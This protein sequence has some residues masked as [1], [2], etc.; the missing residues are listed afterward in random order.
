[1]GEGMGR[2]IGGVS[3]LGGESSLGGGIC[4][5]SIR[6]WIMACSLLEASAAEHWKWSIILPLAR[7]KVSLSCSGGSWSAISRHVITHGA[8]GDCKI[9]GGESYGLMEGCSE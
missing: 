1:M 8:S 9:E 3:G 7:L 4:S 6:F 5:S 2:P